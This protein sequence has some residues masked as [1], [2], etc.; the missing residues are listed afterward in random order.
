MPYEHERKFLVDRTL[1]P[2]WIFKGPASHLQQGY[3]CSSPVVRV[4]LVGSSR[5]SMPVPQPDGG[6][7]DSRVSVWDCGSLTIKGPGLRSRAEYEYEIPLE[8]AANLYAMCQHRLAKRRYQIPHAGHAWI[9]DEYQ[10][11]LAGLWTGEI[12]LPE[13]DQLLTVQPPVWTV[14]EVIEDPRYTGSALATSG[15]VPI[16]I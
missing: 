13:A 8:D 11:T 2:P 3:L 12:E 9:V 1:L 15:T 4:R 16:R 6:T 14:L 7:F 10:D 5:T